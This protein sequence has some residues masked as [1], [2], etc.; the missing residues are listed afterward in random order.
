M[1]YK[2]TAI[3]NLRRYQYEFIIHTVPLRTGQSIHHVDYQVD[4]WEALFHTLS[5]LDDESRGSYYI[6]CTIKIFDL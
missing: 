3:K 2:N 1:C 4:W 6:I 5:L